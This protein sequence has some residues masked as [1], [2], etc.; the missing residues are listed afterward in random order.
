LF[1]VLLGAI[2]VWAGEHAWLVVAHLLGGTLLW[3]SMVYVSLLAHAAPRP[4]TA[5][6]PGGAI[7]AVPA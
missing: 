5:R 6:E 4:V 2:N 1:Q 7:E 3:S